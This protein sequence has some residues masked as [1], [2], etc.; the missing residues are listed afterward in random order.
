LR[1]DIYT[2]SKRRSIGSLVS[3]EG[4][5]TL[6]SEIAAELEKRLGAGVVKA[7]YFTKFYI[8]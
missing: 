1:G 6:G 5:G 8:L 4:R 7:V 3:P 2:L